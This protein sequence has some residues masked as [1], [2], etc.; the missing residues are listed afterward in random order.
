M[1]RVLLVSADRFLARKCELALDG[2]A[3]FE[4]VT[5]Y[6]TDRFFDVCLWDRDTVGEPGASGSVLTLSRHDECDIRVPFS[7]ETIC[8]VAQDDAVG[9][10]MLECRG[11]HAYLRGREIKLT[12][13]ESALLC[14]LIDA[15][16]EFVSRDELLSD[17]WGDGCDSGII[18]VYI[19]YLRDKLEDGEKIIISSRKCGYKIEG[20]YIGCSE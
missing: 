20:R 12:E 6:S 17:V 16:G 18:N 14:R 19:H 8:A 13:L 5:S 3:I 7:F 11:R 15:E 4:S 2:I 1:R 9:A 10:P